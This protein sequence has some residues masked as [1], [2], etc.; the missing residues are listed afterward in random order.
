MGEISTHLNSMGAKK[1]SVG[2]LNSGRG[3]GYTSNNASQSNSLLYPGISPGQPGKVEI[4][5]FRPAKWGPDGHLHFEDN[6]L[7]DSAYG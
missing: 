5:G 3:E 4:V 6:G 7:P 2:V 1:Q